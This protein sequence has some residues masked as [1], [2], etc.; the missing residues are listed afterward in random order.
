MK[1]LFN[2]Q[3]MQLILIFFIA[4][5]MIMKTTWTICVQP[6]RSLII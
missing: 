5:Q 1:Y 3:Y 4:R 6:Y 2:F